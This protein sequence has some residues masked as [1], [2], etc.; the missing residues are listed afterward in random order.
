MT[1]TPGIERAPGNTDPLSTDIGVSAVGLGCN[2]FGRPGSA[3]ESQE[4]TAAVIHA[5]IDSGITLFDTADLYG[6]SFGRSE[7]MMGEALGARRDQI[8]LATKFGFPD[9]GFAHDGARGSRDYIR[10][11]VEGS[12]SRLKTDRIDLYQMHM[13][14]PA[15]PIE[16][17]L[18]ALDELV[19]EGKVR[20]IGHS[21]FSAAQIDEAATAATSL[22]V[23]AFVT[24][25]N[26]LSLLQRETDREISPAIRRHGLGLLPFFPLANGML[27]G[28]YTRDHMPADTR[29][30]RQ[31][32]EVFE[33][34]NWETLDAYR[35]L[36]EQ[37]GVSMLEATFGW[38]L[39]HDPILS[40]IAG[41]TTPE[42]VRQNVLAGEAFTPT[43]EQ[44]TQIETLFPVP[45]DA[46][47]EH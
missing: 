5:A 37:W 15:T 24:A 3:T 35:V 44:R 33:Q 25:Q 34:A 14:D 17:T 47:G 4:G 2:N 20:S 9:S 31:K 39:S 40:V 21:N 22:G 38:M 12:L 18:T 28:K 16:E 45:K 10:S 8:V 43:L 42:Q 1:R 29:I 27:T 32:R 23:T 26:E 36:C 46:Q 30:S 7:E 19:L 13:P 41:A 6:Y 11:A